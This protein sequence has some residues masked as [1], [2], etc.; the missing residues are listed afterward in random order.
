MARDLSNKEYMVY[1]HESPNGKRYVGITCVNERT[2]WEL[3]GQGYKTNKHFWNAIQKYGWDNFEHYILFEGLSQ[4]RAEDK[5][6]ELIALWDTTNPQKGYNHDSGGNAGKHLSEET[7][8]KLS[9]ATKKYFE[10]HV[11]YNLG[12]SMSEE[13]KKK[14]SAARIGIKW[15]D[16]HREKELARRKA[17]PYKHSEEAKAKIRNSNRENYKRRS[18]S[19]CQYDMDGNFIRTFASIREAVRETG[20]DRQ[21]LS[22]CCNK[23]A[24]SAG[25]FFWCFVDREIQL[26]IAVPQKN[27]TNNNSPSK[28]LQYSLDNVL[29]GEY[30]NS[31]QL[32]EAGYDVKNVRRCC[33]HVRKTYSGFKWEYKKEG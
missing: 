16:E 27:I 9:E 1:C 24:L 8:K 5:E 4:K 28:Y 26:K 7:K 10:T 2:R 19:V 20:V 25:G 31:K 13:T 14:I 12:K 11:P 22:A 29:L 30:E 17:N 18:K 23:T 32:K 33:N 21:Q 15:S 6:R 3:K